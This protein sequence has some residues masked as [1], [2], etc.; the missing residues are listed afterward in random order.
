M[1]MLHKLKPH[2]LGSVEDLKLDVQT[3]TTVMRENVVLITKALH[4]HMIIPAFDVFC[5]DITKIY[6]KV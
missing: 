3:F 5:D 4:N 6:E 2:T 1:K